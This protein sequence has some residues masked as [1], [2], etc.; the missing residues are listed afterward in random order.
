MAPYIIRRI[1]SSSGVLLV[2][3]AVMFVLVNFAGD[4]VLMLLPADASQKDV[5]ELR[6]NLGLDQPLVIRYG[7]FLS[8]AVR[9]DL[10]TSFYHGESALK[11]ITERLPASMELLIGATL[12]SVL[13]AVPLGVVCATNRG[14]WIDK[15]LLPLSLIGISAP[16]FWVAL[17]LILIFSLTLHWLPTLGRGSLAHLVL[18]ATSLA[19]YRLALGMRFIRSGMLDVLGQDFVRTAR[20][21]GLSERVVVYKHGLRNTL[22]PFVTVVGLQMGSALAHAIVTERIFAWPGMGRLLIESIEKVDPPVIVAYTIVTGFIF[23]LINLSVDI[24]YGL[25]DPRIRYN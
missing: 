16:G 24:A 20:A 23:V 22:I 15:L 10:G 1:V 18:P 21:K 12:L 7:K 6:H 5:V 9:G 13:A 8:A 17:M 19:L 25:L 3:S 2:I 4:P 14:K 11:L